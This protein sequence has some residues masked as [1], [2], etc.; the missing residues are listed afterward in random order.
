MA[1]LK[2]IFPLF[3][4]QVIIGFGQT[5]M[6][7]AGEL[8][9]KADSVILIS[10][11]SIEEYHD[12]RDIVYQPDD[13]ISEMKFPSL[14]TD[15]DI[16]PAV[17]VQKKYLLK[18]DITILIHIVQKPVKKTR[19]GWLPLCFEPHHAILIYIKGRLSYIDFCFSCSQLATS[20]DIKLDNMDFRDGKW[21]EIK[22]FFLKYGL[23][24]EMGDID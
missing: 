5:H 14:F 23:T 10:H 3:L 16:N 19:I 8:I 13:S 11:V 20:P 1:A 12:K 2:F 9:S 24:Y 4:F 7:A 18:K 22:S 6:A 17:I 21:K 15:T